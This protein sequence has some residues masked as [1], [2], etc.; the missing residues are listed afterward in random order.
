M[1]KDFFYF[2]KRERQGIVILAVLIVGVLVGK[3]FFSVPRSEALEE[4]QAI[5]VLDNQGNATGNYVPLPQN[6][7]KHNGTGAPL[8]S[9][10]S[11]TPVQ[12][13]TFYAHDRDTI[14]RPTPHINVPKAEKF[15][16]G[17]TLELNAAD[18][19][20]LKKIPGVGSSFAKRIVAYRNMLGG[21]HRVEQLQE[22]YGMYVELFEQL[23][24]YIKVDDA[25][26]TRIE[27]NKAGIDKL[28]NHP[29]LNFYQAKAII[30]TRKKRGKLQGIE[31]LQLLEEFTA[32]DW[33]RITP[34]LDFQ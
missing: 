3:W 15:A 13:R 19:L 20:E 8:R 29:Y 18:T 23:S 22:V 26:I 16:K 6:A 4:T 10:S 34:Y 11:H 33:L 31:D 17:E 9:P 21:Y 14:M 30:E 27:V 7:P 24:P 1:F 32:D 5:E 2:S 12:T 28:R 25:S